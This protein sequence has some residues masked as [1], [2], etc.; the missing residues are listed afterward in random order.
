MRQRVGFARALVVEPDVLMM[1]EPLSAL[2]VLTAE[3]LRGELIHRHLHRDLPSSSAARAGC[4][5]R[6][7]SVMNH[8]PAIR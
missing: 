6:Q 5:R 8:H 7:K 4:E 2:D 3:N 1:D